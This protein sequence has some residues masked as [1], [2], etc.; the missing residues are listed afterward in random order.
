MNP[1]NDVP[2]HCATSNEVPADKRDPEFA[3]GY[4]LTAAFVAVLIYMAFPTIKTL[5]GFP[6]P[7]VEVQALGTVQRVLYVGGLITDTQVDTQERS[8]LL[9]G[10][11]DLS[12]NTPLDLR[13]QDGLSFVCISG[14][15]NC[16]R[17][18]GH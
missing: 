18:L 14:K 6:S 1:E 3:F 10:I 13:I 15:S 17:L 11:V 7:V 12:S 9:S 2:A 16:W 4:F 5:F 8:L